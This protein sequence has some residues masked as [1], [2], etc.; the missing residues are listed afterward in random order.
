M[1]Y[2]SM[3]EGDN[4]DQSVLSSLST[5]IINEWNNQPISFVGGLIAIVTALA[6]FSFSIPTLFSA[7]A[8]PE[9]LTISPIAKICLFLLLEGSLAYAFGYAFLVLREAGT[10]FPIVLIMVNGMVSAWVSAF[11]SIWLF[12][13]NLAQK[14]DKSD[15]PVNADS[16]DRTDIRLFFF[17]L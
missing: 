10:G 3:A 2:F 6:N 9:I 4:K 7:S 12:I 5:R 11:N 8:F 1:K 15:V 16:I 14:V 13:L 17:Y